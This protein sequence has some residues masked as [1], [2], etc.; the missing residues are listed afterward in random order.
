MVQFL[1]QGITG[2]RDLLAIPLSWQEPYIRKCDF[3]N[4]TC[5]SI[6]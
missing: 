5:P 6:K 1:G 4:Y 2:A 3:A